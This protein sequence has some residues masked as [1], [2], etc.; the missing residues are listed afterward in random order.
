MARLVVGPWQKG[1]VRCGLGALA[2]LVLV[3]SLGTTA[4]ADVQPLEVSE[5]RKDFGVSSGRAE[6]ALEVQR[7]GAEENI[8]QGLENALG[9][10]YAGIW[11]DNS[12]GEF[13]VPVVSGA[14]EAAV[15]SEFLRIGLAKDFRTAPVEA[16]LVELEGAQRRIDGDLG[17]RELT[18]ATTSI[19]PG[20]NA[21]VV[22][23]DESASASEEQLVDRVTADERGLATTTS[24][25]VP[26]LGDEPVAC[27]A[28]FNT[29]VCDKPLRGGVGIYPG[30]GSPYSGGSAGCT[31]GFKALGLSNGSRYMLTAGH[32]GKV[33]AQWSSYDSGNPVIPQ[34][35]YIGATTQRTF[36]GGDWAKIDVTGRP[37]WD[38]GSWPVLV[39]NWGYDQ[40]QSITGEGVSFKG[41]YVCHSGTTTATNCGYVSAVDQSTTVEDPET[42]QSLALNHL[43]EVQNV[44]IDKGDSGGPVFIG[45]TALGIVSVGNLTASTCANRV[46]KYMEITEAT[47]ALGVTVAPR[48]PKVTIEPPPAL[49][50][51]PGWVTL[52]GKVTAPNVTVSGSVNIK[53]FK[54]NTSTTKWDEKA[55]VPATVNGNSFEI[56]NWNGVGPGSWIAQAVFPAQGAFGEGSSSTVTEGAFTVKDGYRIISQSPGK[57]VDVNGGSYDNLATIQQWDCLEANTHQNQIFTLV[58]TGEGFFQIKNRQSGRCLDV[59]NASGADGATVMQYTCNPSSNNQ[60]WQTVSTGAGYFEVRAKHSNKC[61]DVPSANPNNGTP[62]QQWT[63]NGANQ[64]KWFFSP[65][66]ITAPITTKT[67]LYLPEGERLN[68]WPYGYATASGYV[69]TGA[70]GIGGNTLKVSYYK[71]NGSGQYPFVKAK[72]PTINPDGGYE[73]KYE[74]LAPGNW[75]VRSEFTGVNGL[76]PSADEKWMHIGTGYRF[77]YRHSGKCMSLNGN[78]GNNG[79]VMIQYDCAPSANTLDGQV[80]TLHPIEGGAR[81]N[82]T[83]NSSQRCLDVTAGG[84]QNG[85][86]F[87]Q[88]DCN[89]SDQQRFQVVPIAGQAPWNALIAKHSGKC[90][91]INSSSTANNVI[92]QQWDCQWSPNQQWAFQGIG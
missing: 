68:G 33:S 24:I 77:Y 18:N 35:H 69:R 80:F 41:Q 90:M 54:W 8:G 19:D 87:Q 39:A 89:G 91:D 88:W 72:N 22:A 37:Y 27:Y 81:F 3:L 65:M 51:N 20:V 83:V 9:K 67:D 10:L 1:L 29:Y 79:T 84:Q 85:A 40:A 70:Y 7:I 43:T 82:I 6:R 2:S 12:S 52:K 60:R 47:T 58:P 21:V 45:N 38:E 53:L 63:C 23:T 5:Y 11:F 71:E 86:W 75:I 74:G 59:F 14:S 4:S 32:C 62:L 25:P 13:V 57:C 49:N 46:M 55:V 73:V 42:K 48:A 28:S 30:T 34:P 66:D 56:A 15:A 61:L 76:G 16:T 50:G 31:A 17:D 26:G 92:V 78:N 36:G 64:Q 44:C